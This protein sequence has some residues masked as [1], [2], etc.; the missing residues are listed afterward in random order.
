MSAQ[1]P[2]NMQNLSICSELTL[3]S[4]K[5]LCG[6]AGAASASPELFKLGSIWLQGRSKTH[7][8]SRDWGYCGQLKVVNCMQNSYCTQSKKTLLRLLDNFLDSDAVSHSVIH[9]Q[10]TEHLKGH[11]VFSPDNADEGNAS[12]N[13]CFYIQTK[14]K[15]IQ[16]QPFLKEILRV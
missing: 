3:Y 13:E 4:V 6:L 9:E 11:K 10:L 16:T 15:Y 7:T 8:K 12:V 14:P 1:S 5:G 2:R